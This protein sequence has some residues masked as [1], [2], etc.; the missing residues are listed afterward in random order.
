MPTTDCDDAD[1][2]VN[3]EALWYLDVDDDGFA[4]EPPVTSCK[5]PGDAYTLSEL[6]LKTDLA[7]ERGI[8][9]PNPTDSEVYVQL[10]KTYDE[11]DVEVLTLNRV[12]VYAKKS[13]NT[14]I[15][16]FDLIG[17]PTGVYFLQ[18]RNQGE[19]IGFYKVIKL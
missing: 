17:Q 1:G 3:L 5:R 16:S 10:D 13:T 2:T 6:Q 4:D 12:Q 14:D 19:R 7:D 15:I 8:L 9:Y 11:L 18:V